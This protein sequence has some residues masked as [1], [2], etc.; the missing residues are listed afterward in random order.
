MNH[1]P[2]YIDR[3][4]LD[5]EART[6]RDRLYRTK[7]SRRLHKGE[8][9]AIEDET[10]RA[11]MA[12]GCPQGMIL[13]L[14]DLLGRPRW[15]DLDAYN[16]GRGEVFWL[17]ARFEATQ[18][19][20]TTDAQPSTASIYRISN[21]VG[22]ALDAITKAD[23]NDYKFIKRDYRKTIRKHRSTSAYREFVSFLRGSD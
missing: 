13:L 7:T 16:K 4:A 10:L 3:A 19:A 12:G 1:E 23:G 5:G 17:A 15:G 11:L 14:R 22:K 9:K 21:E 20:D 18:P 8:R 6:L 2:T